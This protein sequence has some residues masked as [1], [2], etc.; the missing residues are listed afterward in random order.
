M[1]IAM[2]WSVT[3]M[4]P[5]IKRNEESMKNSHS[6]YSSGKIYTPRYLVPINEYADIMRAPEGIEHY[7]DETREYPVPDP[8]D[9]FGFAGKYILNYYKWWFGD[10]KEFRT[11]PQLIFVVETLGV[12][13][14]KDYTEYVRRY[15]EKAVNEDWQMKDKIRVVEI[16]DDIEWDIYGHD[17][18]GEYIAEK[19]RT[20]S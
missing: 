9:T 13:A 14:H 20:W 4:V 12:R 7:E 1:L 6:V 17:S 8:F 18:G 5:D 16:P 3:D 19:H 10:D 11:N 15:G 2:G